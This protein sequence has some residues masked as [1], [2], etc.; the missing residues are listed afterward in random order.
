MGTL[1]RYIIII[2]SG[3]LI[4]SLILLVYYKKREKRRRIKR[5]EVSDWR[6][7][8]YLGQTP[9]NMWPD[10][11]VRDLNNYP[12]HPLEFHNVH[13]LTNNYSYGPSLKALLTKTGHQDKKFLFTSGDVEHH[14][15]PISL[16][17]VRGP[18]TYDGVILRCLHFDRHWSLVMN[19]RK[20]EKQDPSFFKKI[21]RVFWRGTTTGKEGHPGNRFDLVNR[22]FEKS[23]KLDIGFSNIVQDKDIYQKYVK[24]IVDFKGMLKYKYIISAPGNDKDSGLNWK[25]LS[26]SVVMMARPRVTSWLMENTL[27]PGIHYI[28]IKDDYSD[29]LKQFEWCEHHPDKCSKISTNATKFMKKFMDEEREVEI[30][31]AVINE[32]FMRM[33]PHQK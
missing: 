6:I 4:G 25:L 1:Q 14:L 2:S 31:E 28:L 5:I 24:G 23:D 10:L 9:A 26:N 19:H 3:L 7:Q 11:V 27:A 17:K 15:H 33:A 16:T 29:L 18:D 30:E 13:S 20:W 21:P 32:Y 8:Y 12:D 22:W